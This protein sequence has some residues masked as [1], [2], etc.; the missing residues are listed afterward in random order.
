MRALSRLSI[1]SRKIIAPLCG[2]ILGLMGLAVLAGTGVA[3][4]RL[5]GAS[6]ALRRGLEEKVTLTF[7]DISTEEALK[8]LAEQSGIS[9]AVSSNVGGKITLFVTDMTVAVALDIVTEMTDNAYY[10]D[11]DVILVI[12][13]EDYERETGQSFRIKQSL[14]SFPLSH[15]PSVEAAAAIRNLNLLTR[16]GK[17]LG[18]GKLNNLVIWDVEETHARVALLVAEIDKPRDTVR[19]V[20]PLSYMASETMG[21]AITP[22]LT[23]GLGLVEV[24]GGGTKIAITDLPSKIEALTRMV[25]DLDVMPRQVLIEVKILQ[26]S[27]SNEQMSGVN[28]QV[29][30]EKLNSLSIE[31]AYNVLPKS[32][33]G[34]PSSG[35]VMT[36]GDLAD[37]DFNVVVEAL[38]TFGTTDIVSLPH[39]LAVSGLEA[40]IHVG[41]SE[42]FITVSTRES[43]GVIN[44]FETVT[45]VDVGVKLNII[46]TIHPNDFISMDVR[47]EV[48]SVSRFVTTATGTTIPVTEESSLATNVSIKSGVY[49]IL[50]GLM[51][52]EQRDTRTG[53]PFLR[54][55]PLIKYLFSSKSTKEVTSELVIMI[56]PRI[57]SGA[58]EYELT[59]E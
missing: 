4:D 29:V 14:A 35:T 26:V 38:S 56:R 54:N 52:K 23:E 8:V 6:S 44:Y 32:A 33:T 22:H 17:I 49:L 3:E 51:K 43:Q 11:G 59:G 58:E 5:A 2:M 15:I 18:D 42:P 19:V 30:Q 37:D 24:V 45:T 12:G 47:P 10:A 13:E 9:M 16:D 46:P 48:S 1:R 40:S 20:I 34:S 55:I 28:W 25:K 36:V 27:R 31:S 21:A 53:V 41:S 39:I 50:G 57:V 7:R